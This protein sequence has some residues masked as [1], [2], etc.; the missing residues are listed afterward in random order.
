[1]PQQTPLAEIDPDWAWAPFE[2]SNERAWNDRLAA[3]LLRRAGFN[4]T[5]EQLDDAV[6]RQPGD[7]VRDLVSQAVAAS[8]D[9]VASDPLAQAMLATGNAHALAAWWLHRM[10]ETPA[11][12]LEKLTLFWHGHFATSAEKVTN[13][14]LMF[15]Q[16]RVLRRHAPGSFAALTHEIARDPAMLIYLDS[17]TNRKAH[18]NENFARELMELFC[19]GEG[20][21]SE[22]D[23][24]ELARC[25]TGWEVR[26]DTFRFNRYQHDAGRKVILGQAGEFSGEDGVDIVLAQPSCPEFIIRKLIR[27]FLFDEPDAPAGLIAPLAR[28]LRESNLQIA[29]VVERL[30]GSNL[31]F[32]D[33][34]IARRLRSPVELL[35]GM[36]H[37]LE[38]STNLNM[39]AAGLHELGHSVYFPPNVK[40]WDGGRTWINTS[41]LLDRANLIGDVL[42]S[43]K[44]RFAGSDLSTLTARHHATQPDALLNWLERLLLAVPLPAAAGKVLLDTAATS[45]GSE[46][47]RIAKVLHTLSALPVFQLG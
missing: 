3:H 11:P 28:L 22:R 15:E 12:L 39:V 20:N 18:P 24:Q 43:D 4:A 31:F 45:P 21:Y 7:V 42:H 41:T 47:D 5:T 38:A 40:G 13:A 10:L 19:L 2:P 29:P 36:L 35:I 37:A 30:L 34:A 1:M 9:D 23:V 26:R 46:N 44:T 25:F 32:S 33:H 16:N 8:S 17:A 27:F 14:S 6:T